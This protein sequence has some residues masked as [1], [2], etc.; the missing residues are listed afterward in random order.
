ME[1][2]RIVKNMDDVTEDVINA[3][4]RKY[5][6]GWLNHIIKIPK[7]NGEFFHAVTV[8]TTDASYLLKVKVKVDS[9]SELLKEE[10]KEEELEAGETT[11]TEV[12]IDEVDDIPDV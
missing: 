10:E 8:D 12:S 3:L 11:E 6:D 4:M 7:P 1:R 5:P 9:R 2:R